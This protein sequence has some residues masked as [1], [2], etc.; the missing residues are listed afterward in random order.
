MISF[1]AKAQVKDSLAFAKVDSLLDEVTGDISD[2]TYRL[3][4]KILIA[5]KKINY[6]KGTLWT[7]I[8]LIRIFG[9]RRN[10]DSTLFYINKFETQ[11]VEVQNTVM[12]RDF[13]FTKGNVLIEL[14][15]LEEALET[16]HQIYEFLETG[17]INDKFELESSIAYLFIQNNDPDAAIKLVRSYEKDTAQFSNFNKNVF[18]NTLSMAYQNKKMPNKS[19][20]LLIK[21]VKRAKSDHDKLSEYT[22]RSNSVWNFFLNK[23]YKQAIDSAMVVRKVIIDSSYI[24]HLRGENSELIS[25]SYLALNDLETA[26]FYAKD[27]I[28]YYSYFPEVPKYYDN[29]VTIYEK[30]KNYQKL[31]TVQKKRTKI[32]DSIRKREQKIFK[33]Y[34]S[35]NKTLRNKAKEQ[36]KIEIE[37][38]LLVAQNKQQKQYIISLSVGLVSVLF[39][40][41]SIFI[42]IQYFKSKKE[43][44]VLQESERETLQ[45]HIKVREDELTALVISQAKKMEAI[46]KIK[47]TLTKA[48]STNDNEQIIK[49][50][51]LLN[52]FLDTSANDFFFQERIQSQYPGIVHQLRKKHPRL[53]PNDIKHCLLI[54][55][56]LSLK[57]CS[58]LLNVATSTVKTARNRAKQKIKPPKGVSLKEY[59]N[60]ITY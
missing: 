48:I 10:L 30:N 46:T 49:S 36:E 47:S 42:Y 8:N 18:L 6:K 9:L 33:D 45:N 44:K 4:K 11:H 57:E 3:N 58:Q 56:G 53:S 14:G 60:Q 34:Y 27:A 28:S 16:Y 37:K 29:L 7:Y 1:C 43:I 31:A 12:K 23:N 13:L 52:Q 50:E 38:K 41:I 26:E 20:P 39:I 40:L 25:K 24:P 32:I 19:I 59:I 17:N 21:A 54:K 35:I 55:L 15:L 22:I 2:E 51:K 5:S